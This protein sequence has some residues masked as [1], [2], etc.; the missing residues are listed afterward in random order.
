[1]K[2]DNSLKI[3][4]LSYKFVKV[5]MLKFNLCNLLVTDLK[6]RGSYYI[7][8]IKKLKFNNNNNFNLMQNNVVIVVLL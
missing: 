6:L 3:G 1:M 4:I 8:Y 5:Q 7:N 2:L